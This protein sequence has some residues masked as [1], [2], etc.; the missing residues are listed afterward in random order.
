MSQR[1]AHTIPFRARASSSPEGRNQE[2]LRVGAVPRE[3]GILLYQRQI[4]H[5]TVSHTFVTY[6]KLPIFAL[7]NCSRTLCGRLYTLIVRKRREDVI[8]TRRITLWGKRFI[9]KP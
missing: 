1:S 2:S 9:T 6:A 8:P 5:K 3:P 7:P 4:K